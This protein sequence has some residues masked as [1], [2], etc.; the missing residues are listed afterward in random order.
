M[1]GEMQLAF[2]WERNAGMNSG[3]VKLFS[4][5]GKN[6]SGQGSYLEEQEVQAAVQAK[7]H[8]SALG[9]SVLTGSWNEQGRYYHFLAEFKTEE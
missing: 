5:D 4:E 7:L 3:L 9:T 1:S 2:D 6:F 8:Y